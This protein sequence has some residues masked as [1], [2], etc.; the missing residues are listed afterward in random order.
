MLRWNHAVQHHGNR[1]RVNDNFPTV[2]FLRVLFR[3]KSARRPG[4]RNGY[5]N[6]TYPTHDSYFLIL[7]INSNQIRSNISNCLE[8]YSTKS[9]FPV[10]PLRFDGLLR[11]ISLIRSE[12]CSCIDLMECTWYDGAFDAIL[13]VCTSVR[14]APVCS[15]GIA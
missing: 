5:S 3:F 15:D 11:L 2:D 13:A 1:V 6:Q 14:N 7:V 10:E 4:E 9:G 8:L 12:F